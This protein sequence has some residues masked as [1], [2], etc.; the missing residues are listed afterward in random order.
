M[1]LIVFTRYPQPGEAK[2]RMIPLLGAVGAATLQRE[3]TRHTLKI[4]R[5]FCAERRTGLDV[6]FAGG[7]TELMDSTF[8]S[9]IRYLQ[10]SDGDLGAR[11][12]HA[13]NAAFDEG[14]GAVVVIGSDCPEMNSK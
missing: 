14:S 4:A 11:M 1:R 12:N 10:Q 3:M 7:S 6:R 9:D 8:G 5:Q 2:S 13:V